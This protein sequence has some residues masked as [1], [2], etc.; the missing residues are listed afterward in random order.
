MAA[1]WSWAR[2][3]WEKWAPKHVGP[4]GRRAA[5]AGKQVQVALLLN[6]DPSGPSRLLP[7]IAE[8][9]G[10]RLTAVDI[11]PF[12]DFVKRGN[13]QTEFFSIR[14]NQYLVTSIHENWFCARCV[15][16][17]KS[18]AHYLTT[19]AHGGVPIK[20]ASIVAQHHQQAGS[21]PGHAAAPY[22]GDDRNLT[23]LLTFGIFFSFILLYLVAG[24]IWA[25]VVTACAVAVSFFYFKARRRAALRRAAAAARG[26][27]GPGAVT[28]V[29]VSAIPEFAYKREGGGGGDA[30]GWAQC[31]ICL[32]LVQV[33]EVV[34]RLPAC[35][36]LFHVECI[37]MWLRSHS[38]CPICRAAV[39]PTDGQP[40][41]PV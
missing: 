39:V 13:L 12:L 30:T 28:A 18:G 2:R 4:E 38:T 10:T 11:Q 22:D 41:P 7:V 27:G 25:S 8:Q 36:H 20:V 5:L 19:M 21:S 16:S 17:T 3:A 31:V 33:G 32:G 35:K 1:D 26:R 6:Y 29:A 23:V 34:R 40:E 9:E 14:T 37:D 15:N 24:V